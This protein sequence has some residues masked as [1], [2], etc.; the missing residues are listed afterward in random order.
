MALN[1]QHLRAFHAIASAGS[2]S[3]A[4]RGL[5]LA[6]PTLSQQLKALEDRYHVVLFEDRKP[7]LRLTPAGRELFALTQR[8][9]AASTVIEGF[10]KDDSDQRPISARLGSDSPIF[11]A[12]MAAGLLARF[13]DLTI[14][15]RIGNARETLKALTEAQVDAAIVSDPPGDNRYTYEPL[16]AD[17][18]VVA[19]PIGHA[20]A[21]SRFFP[22]CAIAQSR[23][24][25]REPSSRTRIA[26]EH[27]LAQAGVVPT[28]MLELHT[29]ET[30]REGVALGLGVGMFIS[31]ECPPDPRIAYVP[32]EPTGRSPE[33]AGYVVCLTERRRT[34][35]MRAVM[36][37]A[38]E[39][40]RL[41][42]IG[43]DP[44]TPPTSIPRAG[45][46]IG[47]ALA[48]A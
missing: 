40:R 31:S 38:A 35:L 5:S 18:L 34:V 43:V 44:V 29:R 16:F 10:L 47:A 21:E 11:A 2:V 4:A 15:V 3:R 25:V 9:F 26:I 42:P 20:H 14:Q 36:E 28:E 27:L 12:R 13:P 30:I 6:Q 22:L 1:Y 46:R 48:S 41:S 23:L 8:L 33:L 37:S 39:L 17:R 19:L 7:P 32:L 45:A 24:L